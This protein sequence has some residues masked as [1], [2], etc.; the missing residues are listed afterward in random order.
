MQE[1][2]TIDRFRPFRIDYYF[3]WST[4]NYLP[5]YNWLEEVN[6]INLSTK[7]IKIHKAI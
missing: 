4:I 7:R 1:S 6:V 3:C 5:N 2:K